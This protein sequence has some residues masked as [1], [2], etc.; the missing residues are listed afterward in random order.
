MFMFFS[1]GQG[2]GPDC[3]GK[4]SVIKVVNISDY[5]A[6]SEN[7][8]RMRMTKEEL[9]N[10]QRVDD[11]YNVLVRTIEEQEFELNKYTENIGTFNTELFRQNLDNLLKAKGLKISELEAA[12]GLSAG[13]ISRVTGPDSKR[14]LTV[15]TLWK[16]A[17]IL[18]VNIDD[19]LNKDVSEPG[20]DLK[21]V[22]EFIDRLY[23]ET[24]NEDIHWENIGSSPNER[25]DI[26]FEEKNG[27]KVF[28]VN[29]LPEDECSIYD[30]F[31]VTLPVGDIYF[32]GAKGKNG[33]DEFSMYLV[34]IERE[35]HGIDP[36]IQI[37]NT[38]KDITGTLYGRCKKLMKAITS[39]KRNFVL[40]DEARGYLNSYLRPRNII[41]GLDEPLPFT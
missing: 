15:E 31:L 26:F 9:E 29:S 11:D 39:R 20:R 24:I 36:R 14:K 40:S 6:A 21:T 33:T 30:A 32:F 5:V 19:L 10:E 34:D 7:I 2:E 16:I 27:T 12:L 17:E 41:D 1:E 8:R 4:A 3:T 38:G 28:L 35:D 13:Y 25:N 18:Q 23:Q 22:F 37:L